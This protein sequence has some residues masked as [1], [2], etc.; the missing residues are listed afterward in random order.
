MSRS[1]AVPCR[2]QA[3]QSRLYI[4]Q[5]T[6]TAHSLSL[7]HILG[8]RQVH[9]LIESHLH[10]AAH[11]GADRFFLVVDRIFPVLDLSA[12][13]EKSA[14]IDDEC[15]GIRVKRDGVSGNRIAQD[16]CFSYRLRK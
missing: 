6:G 1:R 12:V 8:Q 16:T 5:N 9:A 13:G 2:C 7:I 15:R 3:S 14:G 4:P 11:E 10:R